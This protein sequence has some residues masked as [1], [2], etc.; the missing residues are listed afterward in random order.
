MKGGEGSTYRAPG[1][2]LDV[3]RESSITSEGLADLEINHRVYGQKIFA[4]P[5]DGERTFYSTNGAEN[6]G[7]PHAKE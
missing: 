1:T 3:N 5:L 4:K 7:Y 2:G 6:T